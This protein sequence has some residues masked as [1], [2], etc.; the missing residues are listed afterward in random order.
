[1]SREGLPSVE[2]SCYASGWRQELVNFDLLRRDSKPVVRISFHADRKVWR[3][4]LQGE[5][6]SF[7]D[8]EHINDT[9]CSDFMKIAAP[10][11]KVYEVGKNSSMNIIFKDKKL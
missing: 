5:Q 6:S 4:R 7:P 1:M 9:S 3:F 2:S 8:V 11:L 10:L